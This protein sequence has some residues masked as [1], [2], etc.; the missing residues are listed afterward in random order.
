MQISLC[1]PKFIISILRSNNLVLITQN[2][3]FY[4]LIYFL[5]KNL[6]FRFLT[7]TDVS[8]VDYNQQLN[9]FEM[10]YI[11]LSIKFNLRIIVRM[12]I[13]EQTIVQSLNTLF[14]ASI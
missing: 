14:S 9:R 3:F 1:V 11:L 6:F 7:L 2:Q 13:C 12:K 5:K 8:A 4:P 10:N